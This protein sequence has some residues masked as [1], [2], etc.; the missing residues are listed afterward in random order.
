MRK[1]ELG[2]LARSLSEMVEYLNTI[3]TLAEEIAKGNLSTEVTLTSET[4]ILGQSL[5][6]MVT[7]LREKADVD[8]EIAGGNLTVQVAL[9]TDRD[10]LGK[11]QQTMIGSL[12]EITVGCRSPLQLGFDSARKNVPYLDRLDEAAVGADIVDDNHLVPGLEIL[13]CTQR[14]QGV[15]YGLFEIVVEGH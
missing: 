14:L 7:A 11:V 3:V 13:G 12:N 10:D 15:L 2:D 1:D 4:D 9:A 8:R 6:K 5:R